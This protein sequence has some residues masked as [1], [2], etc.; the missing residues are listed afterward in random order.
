MP[1]RLAHD[2]I[3]L[4]HGDIT[5]RLR[6]SLR[7][8]LLMAQ[9]FTLEELQ[10]QI[11]QCHLGTISY[12]VAIGCGDIDQAGRLIAAKIEGGLHRLQDLFEGL[13]AFIEQ[14]FGLSNDDNGEAQTGMPASFVD[15]FT[16]LFEFATGWLQWTPADT[17]AAT[18]A[19]IIHARKGRED[20]LFQTFVWVTKE[21]EQTVYTTE[22]LKQVEDLGYDPTFNRDA[23]DAFRQEFGNGA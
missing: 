8:G 14:S 9:K 2:P 6:P 20:M 13:L 1:L 4:L 19:E 10:E 7:A 21:Q 18:P 3:L 11:W 12:L 17:W 23:F 15:V 22:R 16:E 5:V